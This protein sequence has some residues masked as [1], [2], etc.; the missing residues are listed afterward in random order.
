MQPFEQNPRT[1]FVSMFV[2]ELDRHLVTLASPVFASSFRTMGIVKGDVKAVMQIFQC[3]HMIF[4][5]A[6]LCNVSA[7]GSLRGLSGARASRALL[8][9]CASAESW[10]GGGDFGDFW[11]QPS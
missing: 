7:V 4:W 8:A 2:A 1:I 5:M 9:W 3:S 6:F 10:K 11:S